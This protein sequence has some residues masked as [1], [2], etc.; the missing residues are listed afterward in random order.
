MNRDTDRPLSVVILAAGEGSRMRSRLPKVLH[1]L[2][3]RPL[4]GHVIDAAR[5]LGLDDQIGSLEAGKRA[6]VILVDL[7]R[8]HLTP[9]S[10][11]PRLLAFYVN[12]NDVRTVLVDGQILMQD[13]QVRSVDEGAVLRMAR[14]ATARA[15][16][17][18]D[19]APYLETDDN[20]WMGWTH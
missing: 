3:G 10:T 13:R 2:A 19:V 5:A 11:V 4:L 15:F 9:D 18:F 14:E 16:S 6:D 1:P 17:R 7:D 12:G 20:F 8:P